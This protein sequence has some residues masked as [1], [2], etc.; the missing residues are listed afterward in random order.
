M[1]A[2]GYLSHFLQNTVEPEQY[3]ARVGR[4]D[5]VNV[6][7]PSL[8]GLQRDHLDGLDGGKL[9]DVLTENPSRV[10]AHGN[11]PCPVLAFQIQR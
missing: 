6:R 5:E 9:G 7:G 1:Q 4:G 10:G 8:D 11:S 3:P 2:Y